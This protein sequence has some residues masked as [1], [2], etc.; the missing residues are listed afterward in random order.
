VE[1]GEGAVPGAEAAAAA[2]A[3]ETHATTEAD[4]HA[5]AIGMPQLD[6]NTF[7][8]QIVWLVITFVVLYILMSTVALPRIARIMAARKAKMDDDLDRAERLKKEADEAM[9]A[10][11]R[12]I[13][14]ARASAQEAVRAAAAEGSAIAAQREAA[15]AA[16]MKERMDEATRSIDAAK[17]AAI[18]ELR[19]VATDVATAVAAKLGG[20]TPSREQ[21][22]AAIERAMAPRTER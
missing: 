2:A 6:F 13:S 18:G 10:Y 5:S 22:N 4:G 1:S 3:A 20:F 11:N 9:G 14:E 16:S 21:V 12:A 15:F 19:T 7:L 8:P 17:S